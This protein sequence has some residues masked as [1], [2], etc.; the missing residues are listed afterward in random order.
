MKTL[1][2][3]FNICICLMICFCVFFVGCKSANPLH[4]L[5]SELRCDIFRSESEDVLLTACY[6]FNETPRI[7]DGKIS[8]RVYLLQFKLNGKALD[9]TTYSVK[10]DYNGQT[11]K[12]DFKLNPVSHTLTALFEIENFTLK[13][14]E[15]T[16]SS[17]GQNQSVPLRSIIPENAII[18]TDA[19][20]CLYKE[21]RALIDS[22][23]NS[24]GDLEVEVCAR[25]I[26]KN[27][28][29]YWYIGLSGRNG[30]VKAL[31]IDGSTGQTLAIRE[32]F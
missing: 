6:G 25:I 14:F 19:L 13:E 3:C 20:D 1:K 4:L 16:I 21:Q 5:V 17:G 27:K 15:V 32:I 18:Y 22:Y 30:N 8:N 24:N 26:V 7:N 23:L 12:T 11:Y 28:H 29:A 31:L 10:L 2:F 9:Q